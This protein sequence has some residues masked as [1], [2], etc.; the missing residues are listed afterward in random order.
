MIETNL[1]RADVVNIVNETLISNVDGLNSALQS[2]LNIFFDILA[3]SLAFFA[4][5]HYDSKKSIDSTV[6]KIIYKEIEEVKNSLESQMTKFIKNHIKNYEKL[7]NEEEFYRNLLSYDLNKILSSEIKI[8][9]HNNLNE[10]FS[11][12]SER[13][14]T[15]AQLT[16]RDSKEIKK[17]LRKLKTNGIYEHISKVD[18]FKKYLDFLE[19]NSDDINILNAIEEF[20]S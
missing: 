18:S 8:N 5:F 19:K 4:Y 9:G 13:I 6:N 12:H 16:S 14:Y 11:I 7:S 17:A 2:H 20:K 10:I 15:M 1:T 3:I